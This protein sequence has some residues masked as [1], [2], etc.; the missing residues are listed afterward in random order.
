MHHLHCL[1][2]NIFPL[3]H[4]AKQMRTKEKKEEG[5]KDVISKAMRL[6]RLS[7]EVHQIREQI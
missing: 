3:K 6:I 5:K 7:Y 1:K 4:F 2:M